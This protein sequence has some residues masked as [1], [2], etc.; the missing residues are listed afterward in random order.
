MSRMSQNRFNMRVAMKD[1]KK[2]ENEERLQHVF[3]RQLGEAM[4]NRLAPNVFVLFL[5]RTGA[6]MV[7]LSNGN[8]EDVRTM[9]E[10]WLTATA[11]AGTTS[12]EARAEAIEKNA[13]LARCIQLGEGLEEKGFAVALFAIER[14][15]GGTINWHISEKQKDAIRASI[16]EHVERPAIVAPVATPEG[17]KAT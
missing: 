12:D 2:R 9:L 3:M 6:N 14:K 8:R 17:E 16:K 15:T 13:I 11:E 4:A 1:P 10:R 5:S 7:Y